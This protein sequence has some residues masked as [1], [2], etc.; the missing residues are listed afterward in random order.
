M[1]KPSKF[2]GKFAAIK[3]AKSDRADTLT[4]DD[5]T[6]WGLVTKTVTPLHPQIRR[7]ILVG[8]ARKNP[9]PLSALLDTTATESFRSTAPSNPHSLE[10]EFI[11]IRAD[12]ATRRGKVK[13]ERKID[14]HDFTQ[15]QAFSRLENCL[16]T[17]HRR[18]QRSVLVVTG[19]GVNLQGV[20]RRNLPLWLSDARLRPLIASYAPAHIR[21]GGA[22][23]FYV[24]LKRKA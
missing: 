13:Y 19:K 21:H 20:L 17:A 9:R 10:D 18:G 8:K 5:E 16:H 15:E 6:V 23:A 3:K 14:L 2:I 22:G 24:F 12:K 11:D 7:Q 4:Q 1:A